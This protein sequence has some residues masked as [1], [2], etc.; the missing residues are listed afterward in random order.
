MGWL[1][2]LFCNCCAPGCDCGCV[3]DCGLTSHREDATS[4]ASDSGAVD[5]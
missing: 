4:R 3:E 2:T 1:S 5:E